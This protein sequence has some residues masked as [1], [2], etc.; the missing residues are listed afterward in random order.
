[1]W[2]SVYWVCSSSSSSPSTRQV[3]SAS[4]TGET[5]PD[6]F[7]Q[8]TS[9]L[10]IFPAGREMPKPVWPS[11]RPTS[12]PFP[13]SYPQG[14]LPRLPLSSAS[15]PSQGP[16]QP[17][18]RAAGSPWGLLTKISGSAA[19]SQVISVCLFCQLLAQTDGLFPHLQGR[20]WRQRL[21][22]LQACRAVAEEGTGAAPHLGLSH[23]PPVAQT[24]PH[25]Q[26]TKCILP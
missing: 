2:Y 18:C 16:E 8:K 21:E 23:K 22:G 5:V 25:A 3:L 14:L 11:F 4:I 1:M 26:G 13:R 19:D 17:T 9:P 10:E 6:E 24:L 20:S 7:S 12:V 15:L